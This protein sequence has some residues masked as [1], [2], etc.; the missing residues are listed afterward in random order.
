MAAHWDGLSVF[1]RA[2]GYPW[3]TTPPARPARAGRGTQEFLRLG[4]PVV[5]PTRRRDVRPIRHARAVADQ[6]AHLAGRPPAGLCRQR[7]SGADR[8]SR[9]LS[10]LGHGRGQ[11]WRPCAQCRPMPMPVAKCST[12]HEH[13]LQARTSTRTTNQLMVPMCKELAKRPGFCRI[14]TK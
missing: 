11:A 3:T 2:P 7:Q 4:R 12:L 14:F 5:G 13:E 10:S 9:T 6:C 1:V 8:S